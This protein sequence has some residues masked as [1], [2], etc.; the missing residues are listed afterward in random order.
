MRHVLSVSTLLTSHIPGPSCLQACLEGLEQHQCSEGQVAGM[1]GQ[2]CG[3][4][5]AAL[6]E[7]PPTPTVP[8]S[9]LQVGLRPVFLGAGPQGHRVAWFICSTRLMGS[10]GT[11]AL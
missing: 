3:G 10:S 7:A 4:G 2:V 11:H 5:P 9:A 8:P 1:W 6:C